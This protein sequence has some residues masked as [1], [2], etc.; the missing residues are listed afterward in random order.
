M[1]EEAYVS[2]EI[3]RPMVLRWWK[4]FKCN[5][6]VVGDTHCNRLST[7]ITNVSIKE[8]NGLLM[9]DRILKTTTTI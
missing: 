2:E 6:K 4:H 7:A 8:A 5:R 3:R 1:L 9:Q